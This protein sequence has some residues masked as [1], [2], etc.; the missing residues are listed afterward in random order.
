YPSILV[1]GQFIS[2]LKSGKYDLDNTSLLL[3]QTGG[4]CR[5]SNYVAFLRKALEQ[6]GFSNIPVISVSTQGIEINP[7]FS[8][9]LD[10]IKRLVMA[11]LLGDLL[12]RVTLRVRPYEKI[13]NYTNLLLDSWLEELVNGMENI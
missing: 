11:N 1:I 5:A 13:E 7:G 9:S 8:F 4:V 12:M 10:M 3:S 2:A 6:S